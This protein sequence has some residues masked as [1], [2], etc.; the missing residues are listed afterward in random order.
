MS[1]TI[2]FYIGIGVTVLVILLGGALLIANYPDFFK[3]LFTSQTNTIEDTSISV[4]EINEIGELVTSEYFGEVV[5]SYSGEFRDAEKLNLEKEYILMKALVDSA[6]IGIPD[7]EFIEKEIRVKYTV[8]EEKKDEIKTLNRKKDE[9]T[10]LQFRKKTEI[11]NSIR[12]LNKDIKKLEKQIADHQ[13]EI[14]DK[15]RN[16]FFDND[17][18]QRCKYN[19]FHKIASGTGVK[20]MK[21]RDFLTYIRKTSWDDFRS[22]YEIRINKEIQDSKEKQDRKNID[23]V[24]LG[25]GWVIAG[26]DLGDVNE[27]NTIL[28]DSMI[29]FTNMDPEIL[30]VDINPWFI[31]EPTELEMEKDL[32]EKEREELERKRFGFMMLNDLTARA[33]RTLTFQD[34]VAVKMACKDQLHRDALEREILQ[35]SVRTGEEVLE[36]LFNLIP[37]Q[38]NVKVQ[39]VKISTSKF[40][41]IKI[42]LQMNGV[43]D[44]TVVDSV[45]S[46]YESYTYDPDSLS[47]LQ[48]FVEDAERMATY[49][50]PDSRWENLKN[51]IL[52]MEVQ[53]RIVEETPEEIASEA[54]DSIRMDSLIMD[55]THADTSTVPIP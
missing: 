9:L 47:Y 13:L 6:F 50:A 48:E 23:L 20:K 11:N 29:T 17:M 15:L 24:Y 26:F 12:K 19:F 18:H 41:P 30:D 10:S 4:K 53:S 40:F 8:I 2:K 33:R 1:T 39:V 3:G 35:Q 46:L 34:M 43:I 22:K 55:T 44:S 45:S 21:N 25:R 37:T 36:G 52:E 5:K 7:R 31:P 14:K 38:G 51:L 42:Y 32:K 16:T 27:S 54:A 49:G 28:E